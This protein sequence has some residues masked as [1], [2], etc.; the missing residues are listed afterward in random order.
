MDLILKESESCSNVYF[1][2]FCNY[3]CGDIVDS[4]EG[5]VQFYLDPAVKKAKRRG[6]GVVGNVQAKSLLMYIADLRFKN[7]P[8][9]LIVTL[10][11]Q[12]YVEMSGKPSTQASHQ[13]LHFIEV[14]TLKPHVG[15]PDKQE[16]SYTL[17]AFTVFSESWGQGHYK[18]YCKKGDTV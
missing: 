3:E 8:Q 2:Y 16:V 17:I 7:F 6:K 5:I 1:N 14:I 15:N 18:V 10:Q 12:T 9:L 13:E 11:C 4:Q